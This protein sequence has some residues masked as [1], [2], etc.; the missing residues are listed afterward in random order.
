MWGFLIIS[1]VEQSI[2]SPNPTIDF[3]FHFNID[4]LTLQY[5]NHQHEMVEKVVLNANICLYFFQE[6]RLMLLDRTELNPFICE[7]RAA[8]V[9]K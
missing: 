3:F 7:W 4:W 5:N 9:A 2:F 6:L 1:L 8:V